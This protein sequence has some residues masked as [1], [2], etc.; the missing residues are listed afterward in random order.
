MMIQDSKPPLRRRAALFTLGACIGI[1]FGIPSWPIRIVELRDN[2][3]A[4][5]VELERLRSENLNLRSILDARRRE[6]VGV[7]VG[8]EKEDAAGT[9]RIKLAS[10]LPIGK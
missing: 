4:N 1:A 10:P 7:R 3:D 6:E 5:R 2:H 9:E 8:V